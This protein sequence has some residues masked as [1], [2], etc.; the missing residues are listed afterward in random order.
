MDGYK[1][2]CDVYEASFREQTEW[3]GNKTSVILEGSRLWGCGA[4]VTGL[5][6]SKLEGKR[7]G[8]KSL[9]ASTFTSHLYGY[10]TSQ[11]EGYCSG[12][13]I[14]AMRY[15]ASFIGNHW[16]FAGCVLAKLWTLL[17]LGR[18]PGHCIGLTT[19]IR[20]RKQ[21]FIALLYYEDDYSLIGTC[22]FSLREQDGMRC[23]SASGL[24]KTGLA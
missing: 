16:S 5:S 9:F 22:R 4:K 19:V 10:H 23:Q 1:Q 18:S 12:F 14:F 17:R 11:E 7:S 8:R 6:S 20:Y 13:Y 15:K 24:G 21:W 2:Q 3:K